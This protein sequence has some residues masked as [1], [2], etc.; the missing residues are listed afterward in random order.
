MRIVYSTTIAPGFDLPDICRDLQG[1][2]FVAANSR[3]ELWAQAPEAE[4]LVMSSPS[5]TAE[6]AAR[7]RGGPLRL[8][9]FGSSGYDTVLRYGVPEGVRVSNART[10]WSEPVA[11]H[12]VGALL[13]LLHGFPA[14]E[15]DRQAAAWNRSARLTDLMTLAGRTVAVLGYGAIGE[16]I[17]RRLRPFGCRVIGFARRGGRRPH[18]DEVLPLSDLPERA[19]SLDAVIVVLPGTDDTRGLIGRD[20]LGR[21]PPHARLV[22]VGRGG[23]VDE[24][25]LAAALSSGGI[26]GAAL[27]VFEQEPLPPD[28]PLWTLQNVIL[29]PHVAGYGSTASLARLLD[30]CRTNLLRLRSGEPLVN[31]VVPAV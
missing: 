9:Q 2:D 17:G 10:I 11:E 16:E 18:A 13:A 3:E 7:V 12:S 23:T 1:C 27:D 25:A 4:V 20:L 30:L 31:Q 26:A 5:Y 15:R 8:I 29:S 19:P 6:L 24:D 21:L 22:A 28:S 14:L